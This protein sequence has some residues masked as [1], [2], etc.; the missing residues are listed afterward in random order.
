[1]EGIRHKKEPLFA[2]Q[3]VRILKGNRTRGCRRLGGA[4][5]MALSSQHCNE[6][7][8][9]AAFCC[10]VSQHDQREL[11]KQRQRYEG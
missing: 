4:N 5:T 11:S 8:I 7:L 3:I 6:S 2:E 1:M 9:E 10:G